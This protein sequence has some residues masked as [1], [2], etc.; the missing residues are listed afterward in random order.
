M[1]IFILDA[2]RG[3]WFRVAT[4]GWD[5][6]ES[7]VV[8]RFLGYADAKKTF[9]DS[10]EHPFGS[11]NGDVWQRDFYCDGTEEHLGKCPQN[12]DG[13]MYHDSTDP[14][15]ICSDDIIPNQ[16]KYSKVKCYYT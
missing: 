12:T 16:G 13:I 6:R 3:S 10:K 7:R 14:A 11:S 4:D 9:V 1:E 15:V 2:I 5:A 8:C